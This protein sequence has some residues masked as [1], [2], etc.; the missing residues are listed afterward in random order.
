M[1][2]DTVVQYVLKVDTK[3]AEKG[4]DEVS[5]EAKDADKALNKLGDQSEQTSKDLGKTE[6]SSKD[7]SKGLDRLSKGAGVASK[8]FAVV[9]AA[10]LATVGTIVAL[11]KAYFE[12]SERAFEFSR[13]VVDN[14]NQLNDLNA[15]TGLTA[16][17]IQAVITAFEGSGQSAQAAE[18]FISRFPRLFAD[19]SAGAG[20][21]SE[22]AQNLGISLKDSAGNTKSADEVLLDVTRALQSISDPTERATQG[23]LLLGRSA[24]EFLQAFGATSAFENFVAI[25]DRYGVKT[26]PEASFQAAKFQEQLAFLSVTTKGLQ[27]RFVESVGGINFFNGALTSAIKIVVTLQDFIAENEAIFN[28]LGNQLAMLGQNILGFFLSLLPNFVGV[29]K[30]AAT[31]ISNFVLGSI[32]I[33][34]TFGIV[35]TDTF[36]AALQSV[37]AF[38]RGLESVSDI[39]TNL[40]QV[41][42]SGQT[43]AGVGGRTGARDVEGF[44]KNLLKG[45]NTSTKSVTPDVEG[46]TDA[47]DSLGQSAKEAEQQIAA[48]ADQAFKNIL[49]LSESFE[50]IDPAVK[51][52]RDTVNN[53]KVDIFA[54]EIAERDTAFANQLLAEAE[55]RLAQ[56]RED[57]ADRAEK[58]AKKQRQ[59]RQI[60]MVETLGAVASLDVATI[61]GLINPAVGAAF[62]VLQTLGEKSPKE[63]REDVQAQAKAIANGLAILPELILS[64]LPQL[65]MSITEAIIDGFLNIFINLKKI[66][67]DIFSFRDRSPDD[68]SEKRKRQR[69]AF[70]RDFFD[71]SKSATYMS[72]GRF[73]PK[74]QGGIRFTGMQDGL[75]MLHRG[76]F[77]V[78]QSGQRPQQVDRQMSGMGGG[79]NINI[80]STVVE[81]NAVDALVREIENRFNNQF[82]TS[83]SLLFGGR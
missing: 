7:T 22:A 8:A 65:A 30:F 52:A 75:A 31:Q 48:D 33:M 35:T 51:R 13:E 3:G 5:S 61:A 81:R 76:E 67:E 66:L 32:K 55:E 58:L 42:F 60:E 46:L 25:T 6:K 2:S 10:G 82:G 49:K 59:E 1:A 23:F 29:V 12:A 15:K 77:V 26:G 45:I 72:G 79:I 47:V 28:V 17:S 24:G 16:G 68:S 63:I 50:D 14:I 62:S 71:P 80:N 70:L 44:L 38:Q 39:A 18:S 73:L 53:L 69:R 37:A 43:G 21:A 27:Q 40:S 34:S 64:I 41:D 54:L 19:L 83:S 78:P 57:A 4:L 20:R 36:R 56:A 9:G 74:A 11:G